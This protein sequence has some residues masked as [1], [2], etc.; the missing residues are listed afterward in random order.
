[1]KRKQEFDKEKVVAALQSDNPGDLLRGWAAVL[2]LL[3][4]DTPKGQKTNDMI[5]ERLRQDADRFDELGGVLWFV[6]ML[7]AG[8][9]SVCRIVRSL[10]AAA[11]GQKRKRK[12]SER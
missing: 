11:S 9:Q 6:A 1:M 10:L 5:V 7:Q 4:M 2:D 3:E 12:I 8:K